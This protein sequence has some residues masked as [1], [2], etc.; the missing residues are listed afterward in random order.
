MR[1]SFLRLAAHVTNAAGS[2]YALLLAAAAQAQ[3]HRR[4]SRTSRVN[5]KGAG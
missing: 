3:E 4:S 2:P 5:G 1:D